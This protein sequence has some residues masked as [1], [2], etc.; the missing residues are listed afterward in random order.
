VGRGE[1]GSR[2]WHF[3]ILTPASSPMA[4][5]RRAGGGILPIQESNGWDAPG[6]RIN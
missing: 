1:E 5:L 2:D 6:T 4:A 3:T